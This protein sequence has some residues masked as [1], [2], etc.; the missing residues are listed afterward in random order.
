MKTRALPNAVALAV[1]IG[2]YVAAGAARADELVT[3]NQLAQT[4]SIDNLTA[5]E[6]GTV[7]GV[8]VNKSGKLL[9]DVRVLIHYSWLWK[10]ERHPG[11]DDPGHSVF[12]TVPGPVPPNG[13]TQFSYQ[14]APPLPSRDDGRFVTDAQVMSFTEVGN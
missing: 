7:S 3:N 1:A 13:Q 8:L 4:V 14:P 2:L 6:G 10:N 5:G 11:T 12:Y 9:K